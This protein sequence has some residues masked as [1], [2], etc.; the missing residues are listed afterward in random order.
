VA[1]VRAAQERWSKTEQ[2]EVMTSVGVDVARGGTDKTVIAIQRQD[3]FD[4]LLKYPGAS[5]PDGKTV[6]LLVEQC[7][8]QLE[9]S[10]EITEKFIMPAIGVDVIGVGS[11]AYDHLVSDKPFV[12]GINFGAGSDSTDRTGKYKFANI[13]AEAYWKF[14]EALDPDY[15][16]TI[17]LPPDRELL[18]DLCAPKW[19]VRTGRL[20]IE[21]KDEIKK[22]L[23]RSTGCSDAVVLAWYA[24]NN[25]IQIF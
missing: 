16:G 13:R 3:R 1:W 12:T 21:S 25:S 10:N 24:A 9:K 2:P 19:E 23:G 7:L 15:N 11:S 5:T 17:A 20:Y 4:E 8:P 6:A 14:R 18:G 22:R